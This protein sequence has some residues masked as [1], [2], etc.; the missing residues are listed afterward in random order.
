M[1]ICVYMGDSA[2]ERAASGG[3]LGATVKECCE[4]PN[5]GAGNP[6]QVL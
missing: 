2:L 6:N 4:L 1:I 3:Y 5:M